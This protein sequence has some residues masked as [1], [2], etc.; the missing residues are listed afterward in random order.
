MPAALDAG[1]GL[2]PWSPL[3]GGWLTGKYERDSAPTGATRLGENPERGMEAWG[4]RNEDDHTWRVIDEVRAVAEG[5]GATPAAVALAW[6]DAQPGVTCTILGARSTDQLAQNLAAADLELPAE[7][8]E[9]LTRVSEPRAE[10]YPY[11]PQAVAQRF[12]P[13]TP[14]STTA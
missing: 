6:L 4:P 11:G 1:V 3:A 12:R 10:I 2:L 13:L 8:L 5:I 9:R 7:A 14:E